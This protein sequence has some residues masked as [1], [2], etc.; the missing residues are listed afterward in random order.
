MSWCLSPSPRAVTKH[1]IQRALHQSILD[2]LQALHELEKEGSRLAMGK[3]VHQ[4]NALVVTLFERSPKLRAA[5]FAESLQALGGGAKAKMH[6]SLL[7]KV[8]KVAFE[9]VRYDFEF[10]RLAGAEL[11][12]AQRD[13]LAGELAN[14]V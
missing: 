11:T 4:V 5:V 13:S 9:F 14:Q 3:V 10:K 8:Y 2:R 12:A 1:K 6:N 7:Q